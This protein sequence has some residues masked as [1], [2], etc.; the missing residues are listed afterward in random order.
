M[1][2]CEIKHVTVQKCARSYSGLFEPIVDNAP[3]IFTR[4]DVIFQQKTE[5]ETM[6]PILIYF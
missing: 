5:Y 1:F 6:F 2:I 3:F 4:A